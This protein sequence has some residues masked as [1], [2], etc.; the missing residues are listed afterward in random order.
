MDTSGGVI[1]T[2]FTINYTKTTFTHKY[3]NTGKLNPHTQ[4][5]IDK[6]P[7][8]TID[9]S[10]F[11][12]I[13]K[14]QLNLLWTPNTN[15]NTFNL[16]QRIEFISP[17]NTTIDILNRDQ[18]E[19]F[20]QSLDISPQTTSLFLPFDF[21][22][23][24]IDRNNNNNFSFVVKMNRQMFQLLESF[25]LELELVGTNTPI[26]TPQSFFQHQFQGSDLIPSGVLET[27]ID[28]DFN[29]IVYQYDIVTTDKIK[30]NYLLHDSSGFLINVQPKILSD[31][32]YWYNLNYDQPV[33]LKQFKKSQ[34]LIERE[35]NKKKEENIIININSVT[36]NFNIGTDP[37]LK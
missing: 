18:I 37:L 4:I 11:Y 6:L 2:N 36:Q 23:F 32:R 35:N 16:I 14:A 29:G 25:D 1:K 20:Y 30:I 12:L 27:T 34:L 10:P 3:K 9:N 5:F 28:L 15:I 8:L 13:K 21:T 7:D 31:N 26:Y 22:G 17:N 33:Y 24:T 19:I